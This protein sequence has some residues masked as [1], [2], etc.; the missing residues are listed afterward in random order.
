MNAL[1][2]CEEQT[3]AVAAYFDRLGAGGERLPYVE[4]EAA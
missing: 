4:E 1:D 2:T 3:A